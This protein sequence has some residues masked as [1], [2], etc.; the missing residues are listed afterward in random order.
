M[1]TTT[2][3]I[4]ALNEATTEAFASAEEAVLVNPVLN[5]DTGELDGD[6]A[7]V[8]PEICERETYL[9]HGRTSLPQTG[10]R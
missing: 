2:I 1:P 9:S 8:G 3:V 6:R 5:V 7:L 4:R 10:T